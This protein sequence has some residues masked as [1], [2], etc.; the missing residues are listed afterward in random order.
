M[1]ALGRESAMIT[2]LF[3]ALLQALTA[4]GL[5][6][7]DQLQSI[8][9]SI[10][11]IALGFFTAKLVGDGLVAAIVGLVQGFVSLFVYFG[12]DWSADDQSKFMSFVILLAGLV[13]RQ[14]VTAPVPA[15]EAPLGLPADRTRA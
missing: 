14:L 15:A 8:L 9:T 3:A 11:V 7:S 2:A 10:F 13:V 4:F 6:V 1:K 12:L 5:D